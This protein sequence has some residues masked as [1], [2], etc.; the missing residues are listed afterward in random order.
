[1]TI[2]FLGLIQYWSIFALIGSTLPYLG[3]KNLS[4]K[5][6]EKLESVQFS[7]DG[8]AEPGPE[9]IC[10]I[11]TPKDALGIRMELA[12]NAK[13]TL[14]F[15]YHSIRESLSSRAFL[16]EVLGAANRGVKVRILLD[17]KHVQLDKKI[18]SI[19]QALNAHDNIECMLYNPI[20]LFKPWQWH[21]F[22]HD[23]FIIVDDQY[24][25]LGG[26]NID[27]RHFAPNGFKHPTAHDRDVLVEK[28]HDHK[29][30]A[31][32]IE[33]VQQ[34]FNEMLVS[35]YTVPIHTTELGKDVISHSYSELNAS[36]EK[37]KESNP[38]FHIK[39]FEKYCAE[40]VSTSRITLIHNPIYTRK[41]EPWI[42]YQLSRLAL[43]AKK[44]IWVQTP[45]MTGNKLLLSIMQKLA[46]KIHLTMLTNSM[47]SSPNFPAFSNYFF[48][49]KRFLQTGVSIFEYQQDDSIHGKSMIIDD[50]ISMVGS[51]NLDDRSMFIDTESML[52]I[53]SGE[54]AV[55]LQG[56]MQDIRQKSLMVGAD[57][58][59]NCKAEMKEVSI[60][61]WIIMRISYLL[62]RPFQS[63][64]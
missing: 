18:F 14:D 15:A 42:A 50:H 37:C 55:R 46:S 9:R 4:T 44:M 24:L 30:T 48:Q 62:L 2:D 21:S 33:Q 28:T 13:K 25:L 11:E 19:L 49:R 39:T 22:L 10:I 63:L 40:M 61:K 26:R 54:F 47:A 34:Y 5:S 6:K 27:E 60:I 8:N 43:N 1:M 12:R 35:K 53:D 38:Q 17:G 20:N 64:L 57:N 45:Y 7:G 56:A 29:S 32:A 3:A 59:Y 51:F 23:K 16:A 41:K 31:S 52:V 58:Q 36:L